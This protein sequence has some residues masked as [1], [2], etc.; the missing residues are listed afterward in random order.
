M[1]Y[2]NLSR[3]FVWDSGTRIGTAVLLFFARFRFREGLKIPVFFKIREIRKNREA[4]IS[5]QTVV[6]QGFYA[7]GKN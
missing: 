5:I 3:H 7:K 6:F 4:E 1:K 2:L